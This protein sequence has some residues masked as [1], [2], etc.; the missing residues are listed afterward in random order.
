MWQ[1]KWCNLVANFGTNANDYTWWPIFEPM[2]VVPF[3]T[4]ARGTTRSPNLQS[5]EVA[6]S[7]GQ[8]YDQWF[9]LISIWNSL[10]EKY[11]SS[12]ELNT[13]GPLCIW[14][15][16]KCYAFSKYSS[17]LLVCPGE[18]VFSQLQDNFLQK[19]KSVCI[20]LRLACYTTFKTQQVHFPRDRDK[21]HSFK[22]K[23]WATPTNFLYMWD[24]GDVSLRLLWTEIKLDHWPTCWSVK[25]ADQ[26]KLIWSKQQNAFSSSFIGFI[27]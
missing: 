24:D 2:Q 23:I 10:A 5:V 14:Q 7:G 17:S 26:K 16:L 21:S 9:C 8:F 15:C 20:K 1:W 12:Y 27:N 19:L 4:D 11:F 13:L 25:E 22:V 6:P 18:V 3:T